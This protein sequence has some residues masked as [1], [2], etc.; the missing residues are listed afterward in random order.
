MVSVVVVELKMVAVD[1]SGV[2]VYAIVIADGVLLPDKFVL[3]DGVGVFV[4][5][6]NG[7]SV[8][9]RGCAACVVVFNDGSNTLGSN[10]SR[11]NGQSP[12]FRQDARIVSVLK[13]LFRAD[14]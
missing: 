2:T 12:V 13:A 8:A 4:I 14:E 6:R 10:A 11:L 7:G 5:A 9:G 1:G 3:E